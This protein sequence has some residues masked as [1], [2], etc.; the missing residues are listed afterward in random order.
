MYGKVDGVFVNSKYKKP[1]ISKLSKGKKQIKVSWK[2]VSSVSG[3]Q[4]QYST[5]KKFTKK[6]TK[7]VTIKGNK[8]KSPSKTIKSLKAK[9]T[10]YVRVR[11]YKN[12]KF[13]GKTVKVYSGWSKVKSVKTK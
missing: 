2:K 1:T 7:S 12:V 10:Y 4:V 11:T 8:S 9:K 3:Y 6:T 5:S 13:N